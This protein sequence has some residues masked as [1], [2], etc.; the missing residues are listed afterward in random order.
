MPLFKNVPIQTELNKLKSENNETKR[1]A[2]ALK[3]MDTEVKKAV[4]NTKN[5]TSEIKRIH[6]EA[7]STIATMKETGI[8]TITKRPFPCFVLTGSRRRSF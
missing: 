8:G 1:V 2:K 3:V 7:K 5:Y 4:E 6:G